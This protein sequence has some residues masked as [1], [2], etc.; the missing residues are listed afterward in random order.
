[1]SLC[2]LMMRA[3]GFTE[4]RCDNPL[5]LGL[6][7]PNLSK[8]LKCAGN[9]DVVTLKAAEGTDTLA[10]TFES[11]KQDRVSEFELK[12]MDIESEH[13]GIPDTEY[14]CTIRMPSAEFQRIVRD[15]TVLGDTCKL[16]FTDQF[17]SINILYFI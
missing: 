14:S 11:P 2:A 16:D 4:Y 9:E 17:I 6:N 3:D 10:M 7:T 8:I 13:L 12:L 1:V 5:S 15:L